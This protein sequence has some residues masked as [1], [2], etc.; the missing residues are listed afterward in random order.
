[1]KLQARFRAEVGAGFKTRNDL[2]RNYSMENEASI[3]GHIV[4]SRHFSHASGL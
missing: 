3:N 4:C 2:V 1:M